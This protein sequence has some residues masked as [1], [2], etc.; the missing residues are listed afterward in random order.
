MHLM[1]IARTA[2]HL[3]YN[4]YC[5]C[6]YYYFIIVFVVIVIIII[7]IIEV[8]SLGQSIIVELISNSLLFFIVYF[9]KISLKIIV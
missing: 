1:Y 4:C 6:C 8:L 9:W 3:Y 5:F 7:I 2:Y